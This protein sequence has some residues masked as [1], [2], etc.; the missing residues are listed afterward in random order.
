MSDTGIGMTPEQ[1]DSLFQRF[2]QADAS[3]TRKFG[4]SGL[5]LAITRAFCRMLGGDIAVES[6]PG[7]GATFTIRLLADVSHAQAPREDEAQLS[8]DLATAA[9]MR[10]DEEVLDT[11]LVIDDDPS[12]RDLLSRFLRKEGFGAK[13]AADGESGLA[14]ARLLKPCAILLDVMMPHIDGWAVLSTLKSDPELADIPVVMVTIVQQRGLGFSLGAAD[15]LTKPIEWAR[16]KAVLDRYRGTTA[17]GRALVV[18]H[19]EDTREFLDRL[20]TEQ[21]WS[22]I[23]VDDGKTG[24]ERLGDQ[25]PDLALVDLQHQAGGFSIVKELKRRETWRDVPV[26]V[27]SAQDLTPRSGSTSAAKSVKSSKWT[28]ACRRSSP[29][30]CAGS[31]PCVR[32]PLDPNPKPLKW[33]ESFMPKILLVEDHEEI[34]DFLSRRLKRRGYEVVLA[35]DGQTGVDKAR[36]TLPDV[37]LLDMNLPVMDGWAAAQALKSDAATSRIPII[38]LTAHAMAGDREK[39]LQAGCD[40]YHPKPVDFSKLLSQIEAALGSSATA[41]S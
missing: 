22:V 30:C 41:A 27:L 5:G 38:A 39:A 14:M 15:Y 29:L 17:S 31:P 10:P 3:T 23:A 28:R 25:S 7:Q 21:G 12:A 2:A 18:S 16:L 20:L 32:P 40:D 13:T 11:V 1:V 33:R 26:I 6:K 24:L 9:E 37:V 19:D 36:S 8:R 34:W 35:H 4:G